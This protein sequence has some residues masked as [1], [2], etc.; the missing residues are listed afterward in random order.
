MIALK[1]ET[2][3]NIIIMGGGEAHLIAEHLAEANMPVIVAPWGCE[4][5]FW[6]TRN[7][8]PGPP[9]TERLGAQVLLDAGVK[10]G[11][12]NWEDTNNHIRNSIWE[13]SWIAG[14]NNQTL[15][16]DLVSRNIEEILGLPSAKDFVIY[17][18]S[19]FEFGSKVAIIFEE[20]SV[21][22]CA[23]DVDG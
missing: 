1:R 20:G 16:L 14:P 13:A 12:S 8:L 17:E 23:P 15:A 10:I 18:G 6:E 2:G 5:L 11:V 21:Q 7:C 22:R 9:L 19:P 3:T 4:P